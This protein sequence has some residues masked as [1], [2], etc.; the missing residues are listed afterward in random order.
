MREGVAALP[1]NEILRSGGVSAKAK[2]RVVGDADPYNGTLRSGKTGTK[3]RL[4]QGCE[5][6]STVFWRIPWGLRR[7]TA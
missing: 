3:A 2:M 1:Y 4:V 6:R 5:K 7:C